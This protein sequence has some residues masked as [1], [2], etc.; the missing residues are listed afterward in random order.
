MSTF[1][2]DPKSIRQRKRNRKR[3]QNTQKKITTSKQK[4]QEQEQEK[5]KEKEKEQEQEQKKEQEKDK[6]KKTENIIIKFLRQKEFSKSVTFSRL[7]LEEKDVDD[8][9]GFISTNKFWKQVNISNSRL[10]PMILRLLAAFTKLEQ[11]T[12]VNL[13]G[14]I[15]PHEE[16]A[17]L[18]KLLRKS[19]RI[20]AVSFSNCQIN[21]GSGSIL[22]K[23]IKKNTS[24]TAL[25]L[26]ENRVGGSTITQLSRY[27]KSTRC[28]LIKLN[29]SSNSLSSHDLLPLIEN[30]KKNKHLH[31]LD[32]SR[33]MITS[34][35]I[36]PLADSLKSN[37]SL[38]ILNFST[39]P[40]K[41]SG[42]VEFSKYFGNETESSKQENGEFSIEKLN[43]SDIGL[44]KE[45]N[46]FGFGFQ[47][48][49]KSKTQEKKEK[50]KM[51]QGKLIVNLLSGLNLNSISLS[52]SG[53]NASSIIEIIN[54]INQDPGNLEQLDLS[55]N[56]LD[57]NSIKSICRMI[58]KNK[59]MK[60][61]NLSGSS[62]P[63][64]SASMFLSA[65]ATNDTITDFKIQGI[66]SGGNTNYFSMNN[67]G[68]NSDS[69][70]NASEI[71][72]LIKLK[73]RRNEI[74]CGE[75]LAQDLL[76]LYERE[77]L[78]DYELGGIRIHRT[79][80]EARIG[81]KI[82]QKI[83]K[84]ARKCNERNLQLF[85]LWAYTGVIFDFKKTQRVCSLFGVKNFKRKS[86][87][88]DLKSLL[89]DEDSMDF[90]IVSA[91][92]RIRIH[93]F[94]LIARSQYF[95]D[96]I[97][98]NAQENNLKN[99]VEDSF[100]HSL[101]SWEIIKQI[102]YRGRAV[103]NW[104]SDVIDQLKDF[105]QQYKLNPKIN[106]NQAIVTIKKKKVGKKEKLKKKIQK[107][108]EKVRKRKKEE[109]E[110]KVLKK[111]RLNKN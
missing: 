52:G 89:N 45:K 73:L 51:N 72:S 55:R 7:V 53:L 74:I 94:I 3:E 42:L 2:L 86:L 24:L 102:L 60:S 69:S 71:V 8:I 26:S 54:Y 10:N 47:N 11:L 17:S 83:V 28:K 13:T 93:K 70:Q 48:E 36:S 37:K 50:Q 4:E 49:T 46:V 27:L 96:L 100:A 1:K 31:T 21:A 107:K 59:V 23:L 14:V 91:G 95:R 25:N 111:K 62:F 12:T 76:N 5:E 106:F 18:I 43:L 58:A 39:N 22:C 30:L 34:E 82:D 103:G 57:V 97:M 40:L 61:L 15:L 104:K 9:C 110:K 109:H 81:K 84:N 19:S 78:A 101:D 29:L 66:T 16:L 98:K 64:N 88:G 79:L 56:N 92:K 67:N 68:G 80:L 32:L 90:S 44:I 65:I 99:E 87:Q 33:N 63:L 75:P 41:Y 85:M 20:Q 38:K 35:L 108:R 6:V 105:I 77:I